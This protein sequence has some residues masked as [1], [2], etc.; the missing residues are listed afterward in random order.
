MNVYL[1]AKG[2]LETF[3]QYPNILCLW[4]KTQAN[5]R[6]QLSRVWSTINLH[7][8][9]VR[10]LSPVIDS[11]CLAIR[12]YISQGFRFFDR[13]FRVF[14]VIIRCFILNIVLYSSKGTTVPESDSV[15]STSYAG[16]ASQQWG[17][18]KLSSYIHVGALHYITGPLAPG[19]SPK[20][21]EPEE[22]NS[23]FLTLNK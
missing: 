11:L 3:Y 6:F 9:T 4:Y 12:K 16:F 21:T 10:K 19:C 1:S 14:M 2:T 22:R 18:N 20:A 8:R 17:F 23:L 5:E 13:T 15:V 7:F